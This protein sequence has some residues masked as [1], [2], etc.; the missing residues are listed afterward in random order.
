[1][2]YEVPFIKP[3]FPTGVDIAS[4]VGDIV[5]S[6]WFTNF[7]PNERRFR[8]SIVDRISPSSYAVTFSNAT[9]AL[10]GALSVFIEEKRPGGVVLVPSFTFAAGP[11]AVRWVG[12]EPL[13]IDVDPITVQPAL[14]SA[15]AA[16]ETHADRVVGILLCNTFGIGAPDVAA[17]EELAKNRNVPLIIDSAAGFGS[18]YPD[19]TPVGSRGDC[20]VVSFHATKPFAIGEGGAALTSDERRATEMRSFSN[21]GFD[22]DGAVRSGLNGKL[23][24][25][26]AAIGLR[27]MESFDAALK[28][29]RAALARYT[30]LL[31]G[32]GFA[33]AIPNADLSSVCFA[34]FLLPDK[35]ARDVMLDGLRSRGVE[36]RVYYSPPVHRQPSFARSEVIDELKVSDDV[37]GRIIALPAFVRL[38][39]HA[40]DSVSAV[41]HEMGAS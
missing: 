10:I 16:F 29:R 7:G 3:I 11:E 20:E 41:M 37:Y 27:Q 25:F 19:G 2:T 14:A 12:L 5:A 30:S 22:S 6:N 13:F 34:S 35:I 24:E 26:N 23:Q 40:F 39:E 38:P 4:D 8:D 18:E 15:H 33:E 36:A 9:I 1:M 17:W 31:V 28:D 32:S 21:F